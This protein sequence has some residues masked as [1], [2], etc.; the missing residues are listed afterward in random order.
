MLSLTLPWSF[1]AAANEGL[2]PP[3]PSE[4]AA[5]LVEKGTK[6]V[7]DGNYEEAR[8][9]D[10][11]SLKYER[12]GTVLFNKGVVEY[13]LSQSS[14]FANALIHQEEGTLE[15]TIVPRLSPPRSIFVLRPARVHTF[16]GSPG[17]YLLLARGNRV[18]P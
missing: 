5:E 2:F 4:P 17:G 15:L 11:E 16:R 9:Y 18:R 3:T 6:A 12:N 14:P 10:E 7:A 13:C 8:K 1:C